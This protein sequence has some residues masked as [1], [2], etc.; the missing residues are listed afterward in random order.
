[1]S[2]EDKPNLDQLE[3]N[4]DKGLRSA[5][6]AA[7]ENGDRLVHLLFPGE[8]KEGLAPEVVRCAER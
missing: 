8:V 4:D 5:G 1:M 6:G 7:S 2:E 3:R